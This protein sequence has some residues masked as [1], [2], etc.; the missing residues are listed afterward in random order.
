MRRNRLRSLITLTLLGVALTGCRQARDRSEGV[1]LVANTETPTPAMTFELRFE[2]AMVRESEVGPITTN[3]PLVITPPVAGTF[4]W[5]S[6][7]SGVFVPTEPLAM[8]RRYQLTLRPGLHRAD[9]Q[10]ARVSLHRTVATPSFGVTASWPRQADTNASSE[11]EIKLV[12]NADVRADAAQR[13]LFFRDDNWHRIPADIRQGTQEEVGYELGPLST[14]AQQ[15]P[16]FLDPTA[17]GS[18]NET[19]NSPT[20]F[21]ANLLIATPHSQLSLGRGWR[22]VIEPG[23]PSADHVL[24]FRDIAKVPVGNVTPFVVTEVAANNYIGSGARLRLMFSKPVPDSLT[25]SVR[26]WLDITPG[27]ANVTAQAGWRNLTLLGELKGE[28]SYTL[29]LKPTFKSSEGFPLAGTNTFTVW[30]PSIA[31]RLYFSALSRDQLA[32]GNRSFP[33]VAVNVPRVRVRAKLLDPA[34]AI[35]ALRGYGSYFASYDDRRQSGEWDE[36]YRRVDYNLVP[37]RTGLRRHA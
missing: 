24:R 19:S 22:L 29:R 34:T 28:T 16:R 3:S 12:F 7:R 6:T 21:I 2:P 18:G 36:P 4:T 14:W 20:N 27:P 26:D 32:G 23:L 30:M 10:P 33:L 35:H 37:G 17:A 25:N 8:D 9:G 1:E 5:L 31:P 15:F 13:F 11:P